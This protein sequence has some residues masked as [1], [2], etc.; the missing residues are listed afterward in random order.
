MVRVYREARQGQLD[1][2]D[3]SRLVFMLTAIG[4]LIESSEL[5]QRLEKVEAQMDRVRTSVNRH[6]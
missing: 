4:R 2:P 1:M 3:A 5:E 6:T